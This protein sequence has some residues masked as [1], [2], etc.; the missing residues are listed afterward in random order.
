MD[1]IQNN[2]EE[3]PIISPQK[4]R[5]QML[6]VLCI[7]T[8]ISSG[9]GVVFNLL[10][11]LF[12]D[13]FYNFYSK[14]AYPEQ[15]KEAK[16]FLLQIFSTGRLF[17]V[18]GMVLSFFS[19]LGA[20]KMWKLQKNGFHFYTISQIIILMLP[21]LFIKGGS[22]QLVDFLFTSMFVTMYAMHLKVMN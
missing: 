22:F 16:D 4:V 15:Y 10:S 11:S 21:L 14:F 8:F 2:N 7:L 13:K 17:F 3:Q 6:A 5:P 20:I 12:R 1:E 19:L 18:S 9:Y